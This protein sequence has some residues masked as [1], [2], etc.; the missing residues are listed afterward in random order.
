[1][2]I[3]RQLIMSYTVDLQDQYQPVFLWNKPFNLPLLMIIPRKMN[4][5]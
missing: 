3:D 5:P 2:D 4:Y 1:M